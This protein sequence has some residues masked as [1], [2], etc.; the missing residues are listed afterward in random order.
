MILILSERN[1]KEVLELNI[2]IH[3]IYQLWECFSFLHVLEF[4]SLSLKLHTLHASYITISLF[5]N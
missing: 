5:T 3:R 4:K 2:I 1:W